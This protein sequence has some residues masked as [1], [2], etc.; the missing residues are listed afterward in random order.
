MEKTSREGGRGMGDGGQGVH[1]AL[2]S[3]A[4][5]ILALQPAPS[6]LGMG[7]LGSEQCP[8]PWLKA[9]WSPEGFSQVE[10]EFGPCPWSLGC[11]AIPRLGRAAC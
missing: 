9:A 3:P 11:S 6:G 1:M 4:S 2:P 8:L 7:A 5:A 10:G